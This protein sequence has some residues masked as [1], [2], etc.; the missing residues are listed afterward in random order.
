MAVLRLLFSASLVSVVCG[1][2]PQGIIQNVVVTSAASF[3]VGL[4]PAGS[5]GAIFCTGLQVQ[6]IVTAQGT[7]LPMSLAGVTVTVGG[8]PAP[9]F[10][11][12]DDGGYQ[13]INFQVPQGAVFNIV[14]GANGFV[15]AA[16]TIVTQNG[17]Q[18]SAQAPISTSPGDFF[19][20]SGGF[21]AF[22]HAADYSL[23]T[24]QSPA[25]SGE[26][27]VGYLTRLP[28]T[29]PAVP[30]GEPAPQ[31]PPAVVF[32]ADQ[33]DDVDF[34]DLLLNGAPIALNGESAFDTLFL[35]L[36]PGLVGV[37][38]VNFMVPFSAA[39]GNTNVQLQRFTCSAIFGAPCG[40]Y[41]PISGISGTA[42]GCTSTAF[43]TGQTWKACNSSPVLLP[44][45]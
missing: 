33:L 1:Q 39:P 13:Q 23:V 30:T 40:A 12:A 8:A 45:Q 10:A 43:G 22:Q 5:I 19:V 29:N 35:G 34:F 7:P 4:P 11:V 14:N 25:Q 16:T 37:Y 44:I 15:N 17:N 24:T 2:T 20:L 6:G 18:G 21:G 32:Q 9:L 38:Q 41:G 26:I 42:I 3:Q 36:S 27:I 28:S 31:S